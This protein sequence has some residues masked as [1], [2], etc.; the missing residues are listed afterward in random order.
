MQ[1]YVPGLLAI[2]VLLGI[3]WWAT[4][5]KSDGDLGT[6]EATVVWVPDGD[7]LHVALENGAHEKVRLIGVDGPEDAPERVD[8]GGKDATGAL[9]RLAPEGAT[10]T[11]IEDPTQDDRDRFG[12]ILRY[13][14]LPD[15]RDLGELQIRHGHATVYVYGDTDFR[16]LDRYELAEDAAFDEKAGL[17]GSCR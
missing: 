2:A 11:L 6:R 15:G 3:W 10:V 4:A 13:V 1:R 16:R 5:P 8:C 12:R 7:T 14:E 9:V 17:W